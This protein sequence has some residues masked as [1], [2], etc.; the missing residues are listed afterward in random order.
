MLLVLGA[1]AAIALGVTSARPT[2]STTIASERVMLDTPVSELSH[3]NPV[4]GD[5][6]G[7]RTTILGNLV[8][9]GPAQARIA[10]AAGVPRARFVALA[11]STLPEVASPLARAAEA[12]GS[13]TPERYVLKIGVDPGLPLVIFD[14]LAPS[15]REA[16]AILDAA[17]Q[18]LSDA[19]GPDSRRVV[20]EPLGE[21][22]TR[23]IR[24]SSG[25]VR[26]VALAVVAFAL[27]CGCVVL[28]AALRSSALS[29]RTTTATKP[30]R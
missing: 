4:G 15:R 11:P 9:S 14:A 21:A 8:A 2:P 27:W 16:R 10:R 18:S 7:A 28:L 26:A 29:A 23:V 22:Q 25:R 6:L 5:G 13:A 20:T 12:A 30:A 24:G 19:A 1:I 17:V 3:A